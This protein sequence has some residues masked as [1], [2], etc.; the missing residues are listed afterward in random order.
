VRGSWAGGRPAKG[1]DAGAA[2]SPALRDT[3]DDAAAAAP[4]FCGCCAPVAAFWTALR[5]LRARVA[6]DSSSLSLSLSSSLSL[7]ED[8]EEK[9]EDDSSSKLARNARR[10]AAAAVAAEGVRLACLGLRR[11]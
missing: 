10:F 8:P 2:G 7:L 9:E 11:V 1:F 5:A 3:A 4:L 6:S